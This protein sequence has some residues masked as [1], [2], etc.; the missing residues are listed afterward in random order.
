VHAGLTGADRRSEMD[1]LG[2]RFWLLVIGIAIG[3][4]LAAVIFFLI[5]GWAWESFGFLG[6][7]LLFSA[8]VL[9]YAY[10]YDRR[11]ARKAREY[12]DSEYTT[13]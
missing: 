6:A 9:T 4:A 2:A 10:I 11:Q 1:D 3:G 13:T 12:A 5:F 8:A 7:F